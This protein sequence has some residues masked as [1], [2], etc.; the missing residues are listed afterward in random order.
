MEQRQPAKIIPN[1]R[2]EGRKFDQVKSAWRRATYV[3]DEVP[4]TGD[5]KTKRKKIRRQG[6]VSLKEFARCQGGEAGKRWI[7]NKRANTSKPPLGIGSTRKKQG[8]NPK[9]Q[10]GSNVITKRSARGGAA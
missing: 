10:E 2:D 3:R 7:S 4:G 6:S 8:S 9:K 1:P 5:Q